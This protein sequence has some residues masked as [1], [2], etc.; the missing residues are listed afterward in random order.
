MLTKPTI[1]IQRF[2]GSY[3]DVTTSA[4][5]QPLDPVPA[6]SCVIGGSRRNANNLLIGNCGPYSCMVPLN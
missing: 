4:S 5:Y 1:K 6:Q 3:I 2:V